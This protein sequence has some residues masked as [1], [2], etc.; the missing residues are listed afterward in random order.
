MVACSAEQT[1]VVKGRMMDGQS[2]VSL[3]EQSAGMM[4]KMMEDLLAG[5]KATM[6]AELMVRVT[7]CE[8]VVSLAKMK[9]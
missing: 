1:A 7:A 4:V 9:A 5:K 3:V 2:A 6:K 8:L